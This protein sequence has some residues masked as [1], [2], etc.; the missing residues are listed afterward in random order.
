MSGEPARTSKPFPLPRQHN[1]QT[2]TDSALELLRGR[3][4]EQ[5][6]RLGAW[7]EGDHPR[8]EVL[9]C[10]LCVDVATGGVTTLAGVEVSPPWR[11]LVLHYLCIASRPEQLAPEI[12]FADLPSARAYVSVYNK[13]VIGRLCA[14][15][16]RDAQTLQAGASAL[17]ARWVRTGGDL[18]FDLKPFP[19]L[20]ARVIWHAPDEE[21]GPSATMLFPRNIESFF[22][23]EDI[24][25]LSEQLVSRL[26]GRRF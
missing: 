11:I 22:C 6:G 16:G 25:V 18:A 3:S 14:T 8:L 7:F 1:L 13:R 5:L 24:V 17:G 15:A 9:D 12:T 26:S 21:F 23:S 19:L 4:V 20:A 2:A 10:E